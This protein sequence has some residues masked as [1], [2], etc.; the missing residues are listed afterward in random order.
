[1]FINYSPSPRSCSTCHRLG[2]DLLDFFNVFHDSVRSLIN[3]FFQI[4]LHHIFISTQYLMISI[5]SLKVN[6]SNGPKSSLSGWNIKVFDMLKNIC[7][8]AK[9]LFWSSGYF[10]EA[11][12]SRLA[13]SKSFWSSFFLSFSITVN[14]LIH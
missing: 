9:L 13:P 2:E 7:I 12:Q 11:L 1:M 4:Y 6:C 3:S 10:Y 14:V 8:G 5:S